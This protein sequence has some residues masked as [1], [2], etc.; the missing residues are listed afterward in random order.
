MVK[1]P[2]RKINKKKKRGKKILHIALCILEIPA[3]C[4]DMLHTADGLTLK[5]LMVQLVAS[6]NIPCWRKNEEAYS[7]KSH[8][9]FSFSS[10]IYSIWN[11]PRFCTLKVC[12]EIANVQPLRLHLLLPALTAIVA[13]IWLREKEQIFLTG[14]C[15]I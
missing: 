10:L 7:N 15:T 1:C 5:K 9:Y 12:V 4:P 6:G 11:L 13:S 2:D 14:T 3:E 8:S